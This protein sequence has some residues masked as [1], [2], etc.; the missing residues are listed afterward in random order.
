MYAT[1]FMMLYKTCKYFVNVRT[2]SSRDD[3]RRQARAERCY[4]LCQAQRRVWARWPRKVDS[5]RWNELLGDMIEMALGIAYLH[6]E[7]EDVINTLSPVIYKV[8]DIVKY[9]KDHAPYDR[10]K[11]F[12]APPKQFLKRCT[13]FSEALMVCTPVHCVD[14]K[15]ACTQLRDPAVLA[16]RFNF[17][18][19]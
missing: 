18:Y 5:K 11:D 19:A 7:H 12:S 6:K 15:Q 4:R 3:A 10:N 2:L 1:F 8:N 13:D 16:Q 17:Q 9:I 14:P